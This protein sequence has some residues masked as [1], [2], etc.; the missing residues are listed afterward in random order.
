MGT[1][2]TK[3]DEIKLE[4]IGL[5]HS[6]GISAKSLADERDLKWVECFYLWFAMGIALLGGGVCLLIL[7]LFYFIHIGG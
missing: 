4:K 5:K 6:S 1:I 3:P 7:E 2:L